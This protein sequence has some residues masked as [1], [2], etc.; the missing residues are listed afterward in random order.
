MFIKRNPKQVF[1]STK[2]RFPALVFEIGR[3]ALAGSGPGPLTATLSGASVRF[4]ALVAGRSG[5]TGQLA[6]QGGSLLSD[7]CPPLLVSTGGQLRWPRFPVRQTAIYHSAPI[8]AGRLARAGVASSHSS[9]FRRE[10]LFVLILFAAA[11]ARSAAVVLS[12]A[13]S[14]SGVPVPPLLPAFLLSTSRVGFF[15]SVRGGRIPKM[16]G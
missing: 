14:S 12:L 10:L 8:V 3:A 1:F 4:M 2:N 13:R 11:A 7:F 16:L 6:S 9:G 5:S 15:M